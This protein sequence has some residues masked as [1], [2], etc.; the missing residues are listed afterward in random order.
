MCSIV[1]FYCLRDSDRDAARLRSCLAAGLDTMRR[2]GP[3]EHVIVHASENC[4][5]G[6]NR[7]V[8]RGHVRDGMFPLRDDRC[9]SVYNG[10]IYNYRRWMPRSEHDGSCILPAYLSLGMEAFSQFDGEFAIALHD[11]RDNSATLAR[12]PFGC[13]PL[14]FSLSGDILLW[15][16]HEDAINALQRHVHCAP[17]RSS[18]YRHSLTV[19]EPFTSYRGIWTLPPGHFIRA[20]RRGIECGPYVKWQDPQRTHGDP[21]DAFVA[22]QSSLVERLEYG[23]VVAIPLSGGI[24]SGIIAFTADA[25]GIPYHIFSVTHMFGSATEE[26]DLIRRRCDRLNNAKAITTLNCGTEALERALEDVFDIGY[27]ATER[28]DTST[29]PTHTLYEAINQAGIRVSIDGTGGDELFHG[30]KFRDDFAPLDGWPRTWD[31]CN[32]Y[33]SMWSSLLDYTAKAER[34]GGYFSIEAR[35]PYQ[36][37][38]LMLAAAELEVRA[39]LKWPLRQFLLE[40]TKY[41][42]GSP[43]DLKE[44]FGFSL[45]NGS[46]QE[47]V[48]RLRRQWHQVR[49]PPRRLPAPMPFPFE[50][51]NTIK[52]EVQ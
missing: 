6:A 40:R 22:L 19:Q 30:Y 24:D 28:F 25:L 21:S 2:R 10:E 27:Y 20:T 37:R 35:F 48:A 23:G 52:A 17:V 36:C 16:S 13:R 47:V 34:A 44:K 49:K 50:I 5:L 39:T 8:I 11:A 3:D 41:G 32:Y 1:G 31:N 9:T 7:L 33:Y 4:S 51:G 45:K 26:T 14:Y 15:S 29:I 12:D 46:K 18:T 38:R 43:I 42:S